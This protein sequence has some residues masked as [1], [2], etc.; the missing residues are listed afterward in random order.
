M[1]DSVMVGRGSHPL[2]VANSATLQTAAGEDH[3]GGD[4]AGTHLAVRLPE[5][6]KN[7]IKCAADVGV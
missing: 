1:R 6:V 3:G 5:P 2:I 7:Q 4:L